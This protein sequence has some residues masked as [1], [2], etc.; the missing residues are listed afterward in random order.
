MPSNSPTGDGAKI[1]C[2]ML[3]A[4]AASVSAA[5]NFTSREA[6]IRLFHFIATDVAH[7]QFAR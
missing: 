6:S 4:A 7:H 3:G 5:H 1:C 2:A